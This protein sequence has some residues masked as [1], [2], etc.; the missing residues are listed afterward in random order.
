[1][2]SLPWQMVSLELWA[3]INF[4]SL[5]VL[6]D[7]SLITVT[8]KVTDGAN[9]Q[10]LWS[11]RLWSPNTW[12]IGFWNW[13]TGGMWKTLDL[14]GREVPE[15]WKQRVA[16]HLE[17]LLE[18]QHVDRSPKNESWSL[19]LQVWQVYWLELKYRPLVF[20]SG[21]KQTNKKNSKQIL[22]LLYP[23]LQS[24][25]KPTRRPSPICKSKKPLFY[26]SLQLSLSAYPT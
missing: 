21:K 6:L 10:K 7:R 20:Y 24:P 8:R 1:M 25:Q 26:V 4:F 5:S 23:D 11:P 19:S 14:Q 3:K 17:E 22:S 9:K 12:S 18:G 15:C 2:P 16:D 13:F